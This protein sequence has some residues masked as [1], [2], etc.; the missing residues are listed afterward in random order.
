MSWKRGSQDTATSCASKSIALLCTFQ[1]MSDW[2][3]MTPLGE[4]VDPE[5]YWR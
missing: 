3:T 4:P 1:A 2:R 5:V